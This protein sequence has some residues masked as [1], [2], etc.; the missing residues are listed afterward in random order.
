MRRS[1]ALA[2]VAVLE[3]AYPNAKIG[4]PTR[5]L[6]VE[7]LEPVDLGIAQRAVKTL[8]KT[9]DSAFF[10]T[11]ARILCYVAAEEKRQPARPELEAAETELIPP[12]PE[13]VDA[14]TQLLEATKTRSKALD[15]SSG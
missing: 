4:D 3:A 2:L 11:I 7:F 1:E 9:E 6:Y 12:P 10:P 8:V 5:Q 13:A 15:G 14:I